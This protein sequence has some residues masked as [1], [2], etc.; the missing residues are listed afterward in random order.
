MVQHPFVTNVIGDFHF[1]L[2][3]EGDS[4][5]LK[6]FTNNIISSFTYKD[7][8]PWPFTADGYGRTMEKQVI[9]QIRAYQI[10]GLK[11]VWAVHQELHILHV[12]KI[13]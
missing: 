6:D 12:S 1:N 9:S 13:L 10:H 3:N 8:R 2:E 4:V 5:M 7:I 11:V